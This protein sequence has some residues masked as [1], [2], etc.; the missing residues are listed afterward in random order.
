MNQRSTGHYSG[1]LRRDPVPA[2]RPRPD[3]P[4]ATETIH[5]ELFSDYQPSSR[6]DR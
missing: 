5:R 4:N 1:S 3:G 2:R 6:R